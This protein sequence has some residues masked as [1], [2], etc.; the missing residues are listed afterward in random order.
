VALLTSPALASVRHANI[1][2]VQVDPAHW[3]RAPRNCVM[4]RSSPPRLRSAANRSATSLRIAIR[5]RASSAPKMNPWCAAG[6]MLRSGLRAGNRLEALDTG[7]PAVPIRSACS[8]SAM[9]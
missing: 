3:Q 7:V 6:P 9:A 4:G 8:R 5:R 1:A 2:A